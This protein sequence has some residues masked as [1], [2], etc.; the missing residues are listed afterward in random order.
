MN[1]IGNIFIILGLWSVGNKSRNGFLYSLI[2]ESF[3]MIWSIHE[4]Q[5]ALAFITAV[6]AGI[7]TRNWFKWGK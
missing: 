1:W 7:A 4:K 3:W 5:W 6:F 2:G